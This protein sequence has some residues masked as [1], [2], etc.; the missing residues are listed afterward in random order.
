MSDRKAQLIYDAV[1]EALM[2]V[3][4]EAK[5][6]PTVFAMHVD[7]MLYCAQ[8]RAAE[9]AVRAYKKPLRKAGKR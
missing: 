2:R 4:I 6:Y 9:A 7:D 1:H 8:M 3:R 5:Q